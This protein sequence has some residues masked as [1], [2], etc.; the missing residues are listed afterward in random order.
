MG[1]HRKF[2]E[3]HPLDIIIRRTLNAGMEG[4]TEAITLMTIEHIYGFE[5]L[6]AYETWRGG[7]RVSGRNQTYTSFYLEDAINGWAKKVETA[8]QEKAQHNPPPH[9]DNEKE[10]DR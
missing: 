9:G 10:G 3:F 8:K 5:I 6:G 2:R 7:Y 1:S 4:G